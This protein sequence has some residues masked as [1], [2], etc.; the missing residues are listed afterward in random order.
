LQRKGV[1]GEGKMEHDDLL[2]QMLTRSAHLGDFGDRVDVLGEYACTIHGIRQ[3]L[4]P[5][6]M[7]RLLDSGAAFYRTLARAE[8]YRRM[9]V[10]PGPEK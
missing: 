8:A 3:K 4:E 9:S 7:E 2:A 6:E 1:A 5:E 10:R